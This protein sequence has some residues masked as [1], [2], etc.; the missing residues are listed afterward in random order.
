MARLFLD[1]GFRS[2]RPLEGGFDAWRAEGLPTEPLSEEELAL[3]ASV[4]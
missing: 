4:T 3:H 2:A 1:R